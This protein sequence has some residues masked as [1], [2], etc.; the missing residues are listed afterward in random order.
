MDSDLGCVGLIAEAGTMFFW[1]RHVS[2]SLKIFRDRLLKCLFFA[3]KKH[4]N[5][6]GCVHWGWRL[7]SAL[8]AQASANKRNA[9]AWLFLATGVIWNS[10]IWGLGST[11]LIPQTGF[12]AAKMQRR[13][14]VALCLC[15]STITVA[16]AGGF[17]A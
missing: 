8:E 11:F 7:V 17:L 1:L 16:L 9:F 3:T 5:Y 6:L 15:E 4:E 10:V 14:F 13:S 12:T 2:S